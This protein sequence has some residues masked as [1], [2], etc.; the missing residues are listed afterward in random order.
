MAFYNALKNIILL[1]ATPF[2]RTKG[3]APQKRRAVKNPG[4]FS[5]HQ[6]KW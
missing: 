2:V 3:V 4:N 5:L 6:L 1:F